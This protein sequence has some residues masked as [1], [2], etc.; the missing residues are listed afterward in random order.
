[1]KLLLKKLKIKLLYSFIII[2]CFYILYILFGNV[3]YSK[4]NLHTTFVQGKVLSYKIDGDCLQL[5]I[6]A[7]EKMILFYTFS[8]V[9]EKNI[10][11]N[12]IQLGD[13][14][15]FYGTLQVP[16]T[17]SNFYAF[18]YQKYLL[19]K[20]IYYVMRVEKMALYKRNH[21]VFYTLKNFLYHSI[22]KRR[23]SSWC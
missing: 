8:S 9:E 20:K 14:Y 16:S 4:Y 7:K 3:D 5:E 22:E 1:M 6:Q 18:S 21:N 15:G 13:V 23:T 19:S 12:S 17:N 2:G 10:Y 11:S